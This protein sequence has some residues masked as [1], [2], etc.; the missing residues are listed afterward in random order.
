MKSKARSGARK[1]QSLPAA[2]HSSAAAQ[3]LRPDFLLT[4]MVSGATGVFGVALEL[5]RHQWATKP[6]K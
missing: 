5:L 4:G 1:Q 2:K 3:L 6:T